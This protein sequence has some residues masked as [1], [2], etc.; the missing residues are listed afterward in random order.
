MACNYSILPPFEDFNH[1]LQ[2]LF[3]GT[4]YIPDKICKFYAHL[5]YIKQSTV[6]DRQNCSGKGKAVFDT[7]VNECKIKKC[8]EYLDT[9]RAFGS[10]REN[11]LQ[12]KIAI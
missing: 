7:I 6:F 8:I 5:N 9:L 4:Q 11:Y 3:N 2:N 12:L 10:C 1:I